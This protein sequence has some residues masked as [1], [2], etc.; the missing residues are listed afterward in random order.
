MTN[1]KKL[2]EI[3]SLYLND[4]LEFDVRIKINSET[5]IDMDWKDERLKLGSSFWIGKPQKETCEV[6]YTYEEY[7]KAN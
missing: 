3:L 7:T 4:G 5:I 1:A 2:K 6:Y